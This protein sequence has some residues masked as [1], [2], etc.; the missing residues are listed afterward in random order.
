MA[1]ANTVGV[2]SGAGGLITDDAAFEAWLDE[3]A[4]LPETVTVA[5]VE[6]PRAA[7]ACFTENYSARFGDVWVGAAGPEILALGDGVKF[8][9]SIWTADVR[10][11]A[12]PSDYCASGVYFHSGLAQVVGVNGEQSLASAER[13]LACKVA[14]LFLVAAVQG[15]VSALAEVFS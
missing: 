4:P 15:V 2:S 7:S 11:P 8:R 5:G 3:V 13:D 12:P 1:H 14:A 6:L 10:W 9:G